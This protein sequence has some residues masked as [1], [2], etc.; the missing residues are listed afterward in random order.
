M[1]G[2]WCTKVSGVENNRQVKH[3]I[4]N[5]DTHRLPSDNNTKISYKSKRTI[6]VMAPSINKHGFLPVRTTIPNHCL[7]EDQQQQQQ[8][9][10]H[11]QHY[12]TSKSNS[13]EEQPMLEDEAEEQDSMFISGV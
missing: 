12:H 5:I 7:I 13:E 3:R 1:I 4:I 9:Q 10:H 6:H 2:Y 8:Q 11:Q